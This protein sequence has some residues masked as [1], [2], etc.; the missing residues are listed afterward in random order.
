[1]EQRKL[2]F[3]DI[4]YQTTL[5]R[6][7]EWLERAEPAVKVL[8]EF[9]GSDSV[10]SDLRREIERVGAAIPLLEQLVAL[11]GNTHKPSPAKAATKAVATATSGVTK[12]T[13]PNAKP[14]RRMPSPPNGWRGDRAR[15][16]LAY[17]AEHPEPARAKTIAV[18]IGEP[19]R[20][21]EVHIALCGY[22]KRG[23]I[24][25]LEEGLYGP[26]G[27]SRPSPAPAEQPTASR[28]DLRR[29]GLL[30]RCA[31]CGEHHAHKDQFSAVCR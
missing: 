12:P 26:A 4:D 20:E 7:R 21:Q 27:I 24:T 19:D 31:K 13:A 22:A 11:N 30:F 5:A 3:G 14:K 15:K 18:A 10:V 25:R 1:M 29:N 17:F 6:H 9:S 23:S 16:V 2:V 28:H 8:E